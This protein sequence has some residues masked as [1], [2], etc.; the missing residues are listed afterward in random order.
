[1]QRR[2]VGPTFVLAFVG[3][4]VQ[5]CST[6]TYLGQGF[7]QAGD[8]G[9]P[10]VFVEPT[11]EAG[12]DAAD[13]TDAT[14]PIGPLCPSSKCAPPFATCS[15]SHH[16]CETNLE[17]DPNNCGECGNVCPNDPWI[18]DELHVQYVCSSGKCVPTCVSPGFPTWAAGDCNGI[19]EDGCESDLTKPDNCGFCGNACGPGGSCTSDAT[20]ATYNCETCAPNEVR[21][22]GTCLD[23]TMNDDNCGACG[24]KCEDEPLPADAGAPPAHMYFGCKENACGHLKCEQGFADCNQDPGD[25]CEAA[26]GVENNNCGGCGVDC[27]PDET[28]NDGYCTCPA[29]FGLCN[30]MTNFDSDPYNCGAC[31]NECPSSFSMTAQGKASCVAGHCSFDCN[32]GYGDCN[33]DT[34]D[35]CE[36]YLRID[37]R[38][39]GSCDVA[40]A[41]GQACV[42]GV[43]ATEPC[44]QPSGGTQ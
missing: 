29:V 25:G 23:P 16:L 3:V 2:I 43:C 8:G 9:A 5:S 6:Q 44:D 33:H 31:G 27:G 26:I 40:C 24:H 22:S 14:K 15:T 28:C 1:M 19:P 32:A 37:P 39:C 4:L 42:E 36:T 17:T 20:G 12:A 10:G 38:H 11:A 7:E 34:N 18:L 35:G 21:C 41:A 13:A 30:C